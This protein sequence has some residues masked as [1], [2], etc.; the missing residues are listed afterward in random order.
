MASS[1]QTRSKSTRMPQSASYHSI[2]N[3]RMPLEWDHETPVDQDLRGSSAQPGKGLP[4]ICCK[5]EAKISTSEHVVSLL[6]YS[7][8]SY[9]PHIFVSVAIGMVWMSET[10]TQG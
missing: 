4:G 3:R 5:C 8:L 1:I 6:L 7:L 9:L 2:V 10:R